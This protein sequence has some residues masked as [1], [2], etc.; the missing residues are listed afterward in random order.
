M[1]HL[2]GKLFRVKPCNI[3]KVTYHDAVVVPAG[4]T[5]YFIAA[6]V[7]GPLHDIMIMDSEMTHNVTGHQNS[8][9]TRINT[10]L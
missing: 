7:V 8:S 9:N 1:N 2:I 10:Q 3:T 6:G 4:H 5:S